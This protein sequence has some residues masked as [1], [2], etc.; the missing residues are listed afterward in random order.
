MLN[1]QCLCGSVQFQIEL[2]E[3]EM[4]YQCHC[5]LCRKQ[6]G[7]HANHATMVKAELFQ[8]NNGKKFI[9]TYKKDT[10]FTSAFCQNCGSPVPNRIGQQPYMWI[11]LGLIDSV[12]KPQ[13]RLDFCMTSQASW[14]HTDANASYAE[15]PNWDALKQLFK[16]DA[17]ES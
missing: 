16:L 6:S 17:E 2:N 4:I 8:W 12:I 7:T 5:S 9:T 14:E 10:G 11:P 1:G 15:L 3:V 13:Q